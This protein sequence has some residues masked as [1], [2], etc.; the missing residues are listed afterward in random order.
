M[1]LAPALPEET[2]YRTWA[3]TLEQSGSRVIVVR[4][5]DFSEAGLAG[6]TQSTRFT[7]HFFLKLLA[8]GGL[9]VY[10]AGTLVKMLG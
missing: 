2:R 1:A 10:I 8:I 7:P 3:V 4:A 5:D 6:K 9:A